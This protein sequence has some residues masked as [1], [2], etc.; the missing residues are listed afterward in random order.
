MGFFSMSMNALLEFLSGYCLLYVCFKMIFKHKLT[1]I[2][3]SIGILRG[4]IWT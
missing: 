1:F 2:E 3:A 4:M